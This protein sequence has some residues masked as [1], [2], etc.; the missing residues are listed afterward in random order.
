MILTT[1]HRIKARACAMLLVASVATGLPMTAVHAVS[2]GAPQLSTVIQVGSW[3]GSFDMTELGSQT[4]LGSGTYSFTG[5]S[6]Q[7]AWIFAWDLQAN[8]DPFISGNLSFTNTTS[9]TQTFNVVLTLP[10]APT[11]T[12]AVDEYGELGFVLRDANNN[13][14]AT[15]SQNQWHGLIN[16]LSPPPR[17]DMPLLIGSAF[18]CGGLGCSVNLTS[19]ASANQIHAPGDHPGDP[20]IDSIGI[21]LNFGLSPGDTVAYT[22][23]Y[24]V[25]PAVP[26]PATAPLL[27]AGLGILS[28]MGRRHS[29]SARPK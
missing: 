23:R 7:A 16:P 27:V 26:L 5:N 6:P 9:S 22:T 11:I 21:H 13:G 8:A 18:S 3:S 10:I 24:E 17:L 15:L 29:L 14:V 1:L 19:A 4:D 2:L 12:T 28:A 20:V 25:I